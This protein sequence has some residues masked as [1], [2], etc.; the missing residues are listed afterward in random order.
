MIDIY[1]RSLG[2]FQSSVLFLLLI[3]VL[4]ECTVVFFDGQAGATVGLIFLAYFAHRYFLFG[5]TLK[6]RSKKSS[7]LRPKFR[8]GWFFFFSF[9]FLSVAF[10]LAFGFAIGLTSM[11]LPHEPSTNEII[12]AALLVLF[13]IYW[14]ILGVFGTLLPWAVVQAGGYSLRQGIKQAPRML[15]QLAVGPGLLGAVLFGLVI[16]FDQAGL[17]SAF[18]DLFAIEFS[19]YVLLRFIG[20]APMVLA[21][22]ILCKSYEA[23]ME[24]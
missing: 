4:I 24:D 15:W 18:P 3:A 7:E 20:F 17:G 13:P 8:F 19:L 22:A 21:V 2:F 16:A 10:V 5:E 14:L 11:V 23:A 6:L 1:R 12:G 9:A